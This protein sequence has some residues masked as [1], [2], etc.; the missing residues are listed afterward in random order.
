MCD[1]DDYEGRIL[2]GG[3]AIEPVTRAPARTTNSTPRS[4]MWSWAPRSS[5]SGRERN[6]RHLSAEATPHDLPIGT[7]AHANL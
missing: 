6:A 4:G 1:I 5:C 3:E 7:P 2:A